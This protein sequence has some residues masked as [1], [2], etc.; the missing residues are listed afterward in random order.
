V[1][2]I[3][4][5]IPAPVIPFAQVFPFPLVPIRNMFC[6]ATAGRGGAIEIECVGA[7]ELWAGRLVGGLGGG[8]WSWLAESETVTAGAVGRAGIVE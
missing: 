6:A 3:I 5:A 7:V 8:D 1:P 2:P 4:V